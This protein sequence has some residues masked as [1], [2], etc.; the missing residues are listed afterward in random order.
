MHRID[1]SAHNYSSPGLCGLGNC[2]HCPVKQTE[3]VV[4]YLPERLPSLF[5]PHPPNFPPPPPTAPVNSCETKPK[6]IQ[7]IVK[8][9]V[10]ICPEELRGIARLL[11]VQALKKI[12]QLIRRSSVVL[13]KRV[14]V[15][16]ISGSASFQASRA[17]SENRHIVTYLTFVIVSAP[18]CG[19]QR[20]SQS[21]VRHR[22]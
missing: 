2:S 16:T 8:L 13:P 15:K 7:I 4:L 12:S 6:T 11:D 18:A 9:Y 21:T 22:Q 5:T 3:A 19:C 17:A 1:S 10:V 14:Q 20:L